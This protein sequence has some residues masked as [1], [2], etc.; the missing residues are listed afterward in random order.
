M[1]KI[2]WFLRLKTQRT[3]RAAIGQIGGVTGAALLLILMMA[4]NAIAQE[5]AA[6]PASSDPISAPFGYSLHQSIDL[7]GRVANTTG[8]HAMYSTLVN[9]RSGPRVL[10]ETFELRALPGKKG[11]L[12]DNISAFGSGFGGDPNVFARLNASKGKLYDFSGL[13]R[14]DR[15]YFDY[16]LLGNPNITTGLSTPIGPSKTPVGTLPWPQVMQSPETF[17]TV[18][19]MTDTNL[20]ILPLS[21]FSY[22]FGYSQNTFEGPTLSPSYTIL[23]Y[24]SLLQQY[25]RNSSDDFLGGLDWKPS[26]TTRISFEERVTRYKADSFFTLNPNGFR[27]Q[28]AD[29]T[30]VDLGNWDAQAAYGISAC[31]AT[32]MGSAYTNATT[33][34]LLTP[35]N[36]PGGLP[37]LNAACAAVTSYTRTQPTR[38][39]TPTEILHLQSSALKDVTMNGTAAYTVGTVNMPFYY[40]DAKGLSGAVRESTY[41][42]G[43]AR[44]HRAVLSIDYG[45]VWQAAKTVSLAEQIDYSNIQQPGYSNIPAPATLLTPAAPN[46]TI[47]YGGVLNPGTGALP[48]GINGTQTYNFYGQKGLTNL[49]TVSWDALP[50]AQFALTY[51]YKQQRILQGV[52]HN[53]PIPFGVEN[54]PINGYVDIN[55]NAGIF[56]AALRPTANWDV[57]GT[58]EIGYADNAFTAVSPRQ[59]KRYRIHT[60]FRP[61][62]WAILSAGYS[63]L[64]RHNNTFNDAENVNSGDVI[65]QGPLNH[66]DQTRTAGVSATLTPNEHYGLDLS[67]GY[68]DVYTATNICYTS[69]ASATLPGAAT[70]KADGTPAVCPGVFARGSTTILVDWFGRDFMDAPTQYGSASILL[71]PTPKVHANLGYTVSSVAGNQFFTDARAVNGSLTSTYQSPFFK[72]AWTMRPGLTWKAEYNFYGYGEG[73]VSGAQYCSLSTS[74]AASVVPCGSLTQPTGRTESPAGLT[75]AR[76]FHA[77]NVA[78]GVHYEF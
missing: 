66:V 49:F 38:I 34:T 33:Y 8:S 76:N 10:G 46:Q 60:K 54:D 15:Q 3:S 63:D 68:T 35:A 7:G 57:N 31:N 52:P 5:T 18:R 1:T 21:T 53:I 13:F 70:L 4:G 16:D 26:P 9:L 20:T 42:G 72:L 24:D 59:T 71:S 47:N 30:K 28:E 44:G 11:G 67:Y 2:S 12:V 14:R 56:N 40:E 73:G 32:S 36:T 74:T 29:G 55:E 64:E 23:K 41:S 78:L 48:H 6:T 75:A 65:Y 27:V 39:L 45:L 50:R 69:G 43:S 22:R 37:I 62:S 77:N 17:N 51:R 61:K 58:V 25:Q 19:R